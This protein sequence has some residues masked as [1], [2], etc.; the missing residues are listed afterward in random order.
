VGI[1]SF[2]KRKKVESDGP[3]AV[4]STDKVTDTVTTIEPSDKNKKLL[5]SLAKNEESKGD[6]TNALSHYKMAGNKKEEER[7]FKKLKELGPISKN[8][9][10]LQELV[11]AIKR[12]LHVKDY[13]RAAGLY[14]RAGDNKSAINLF[15]IQLS[16]DVKKAEFYFALSDLDKI[17]GILN[18]DPE[19]KSDKNYYTDISKEISKLEP[20]LRGKKDLQEKMEEIFRK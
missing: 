4:K 16:E 15:L 14:Q 19:L 20:W 9:E 8:R 11:P 5:N 17:E 10:I 12:E 6:Y 13:R 18:S 3:K 7:I 2:L 1:L